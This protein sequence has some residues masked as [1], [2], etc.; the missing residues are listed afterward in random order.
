MAGKQRPKAGLIFLE[1]LLLAGLVWLLTID[2][3]DWIIRL[4]IRTAD[5]LLPLC[6]AAWALLAVGGHI[7][8]MVARHKARKEPSPGI[9]VT[10][11]PDRALSP[12]EIRAELLRFQTI[13]P[14]LRPLLEQGLD[15]LDN[16][17]RKKAKM[18]E[19]LERNEVSLLGEASA[20]LADAEQTLCRKLALVLN[21][22]LLCDPE[23]E[24]ARRREAVYA[25]HARSIQAFLADNED[26]LN[27]CE[28]LLTETVRYVE[29]KKAGR[30]SM[31]L[32]IMTGV[33]RSL[34]NDGIRMDAPQGG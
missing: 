13:R 23:E 22:A 17:G 2:R 15:Q 7:A 32:Q 26:V 1:A 30:D 27:R 6:W 21:R 19:L 8:W 25:E 24:N 3:N 34:T 16:I 29:E 11:A 20:A 5:V 31:D 9:R 12:Q 4:G 28:T 10:F 33:I 18:G 14:Q